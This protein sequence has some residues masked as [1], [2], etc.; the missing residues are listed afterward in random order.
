L[1]KIICIS[2]TYLTNHGWAGLVSQGLS[3][4]G[5]KPVNVVVA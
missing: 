5:K 2:M 4:A 3:C 1:K